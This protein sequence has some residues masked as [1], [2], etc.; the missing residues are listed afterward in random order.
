MISGDQVYSFLKFESGV[1]R[2]QRVPETETLGR[3]HT[4]TVTVLAL[5]E[6]E[7]IDFE[8]D[9]KDI[10]IDTMTSS[11][12][13][14]QSVNTTQSAVRLTYIPTG[15]QVMSQVAK[16]QY[17]NKDLAYKLLKTRLYDEMLAK[18]EQEESNT[19]HQFIKRGNRSEKIRT[20]NYPQ[21]R[22]T[23]HRI[24]LTLQSL[25][26]VMEGKLEAIIEGLNA[27]EQKQK[28]EKQINDL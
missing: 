12:P 19:R 22:L 10:R 25:N 8:L 23:D 18:K 17:E 15:Q 4:S 14:G 16:S 7:D 26:L 1:H 24:G 13:G 5:P 3:I 9:W 2:V 6:A 28:L 21:N 27:D 11:G 20:Y